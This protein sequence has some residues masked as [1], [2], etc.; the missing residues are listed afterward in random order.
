MD[1]RDG[2]RV[3]Q[4]VGCPHSRRRIWAAS[5]RIQS[6]CRDGRPIWRCSLHGHVNPMEFA[7]SWQAASC[8]AK[9]RLAPLRFTKPRAAEL[10]MHE[11]RL[12][13]C[14]VVLWVRKYK[15]FQGTLGNLSKHGL[16]FWHDMVNHGPKKKVRKR[17]S[18]P[19]HC[20]LHFP[21]DLP[22]FSAEGPIP[23][24]QKKHL[25]TR[26][27]NPKGPDH[28]L[29][30]VLTNETPGSSSGAIAHCTPLISHVNSL[31]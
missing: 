10:S 16:L 17:S 13:V 31:A 20:F 1:D 8:V 4:R 9:R 21:W 29:E 3:V 24:D 5:C 18:F 23:N 25:F 11:S 27:P 7:A 28:V 19:A 12:G 14:C 2:S 30:K 26:S 6:S 15:K 22:T